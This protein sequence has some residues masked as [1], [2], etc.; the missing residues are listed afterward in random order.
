MAKLVNDGWPFLTQLICNN[1]CKLANTH[2][3]QLWGAD[4]VRR[5]VG[6]KMQRRDDLVSL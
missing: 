3:D 2:L 1:L 5:A 4:L 6:D